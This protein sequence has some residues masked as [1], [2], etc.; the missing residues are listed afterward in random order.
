MS[1]LDKKTIYIID[2]SSLL[3]RS[4]YGLTSM[5]TSKGVP[6]QAIY[7]FCRAIKKIIDEMAPYLMVIAWDSAGQTTRKKVYDAYKAH[8]QATPNDLFEQKEAI[9]RWADEVG[10]FQLSVEGWEADDLIAQLVRE[11][12]DKNIL[13]IG[14]D[15]DLHQLVSESVEMYDPMKKQR[16]TKADIEK[17]YGFEVFKIPFFYALVGDSSDNIPGVKG[18]GE[19]GATALVQQFDSLDQMYEQIDQ[20]ASERTKKALLTHEKEARLS[21]QLFTLDAPEISVSLDQLHFDPAWWERGYQFFIEHEFKSLVPVGFKGVHEKKKESHVYETRE[22][23]VTLD[24][25]K[26]IVLQIRSIGACAVDTETMGESVFDQVMVG[27]S[28]AYNDYQ[29]FYI[30]LRHVGEEA[31]KKQIS[32][33]AALALIKPLFEDANIKKIFHHAKFDMHVFAREGINVQGLYFDSLIAASL[34]RTSDEKIGL[35]VLSERLLQEPMQTF[36]EVLQKHKNFSFVPL[37]QALN[38]AAYDAL[39]TYKLWQLFEKQFEQEVTLKKLFFE[40]EMPL[41]NVLFRMERAGILLDLDEM[42]Q[43]HVSVNVRI[44]EAKQKIIGFLEAQGIEAPAEINLN[45]PRQIEKLLFDDL[46][47]MPRGKSPKGARSTNQD[48]LIALSKEHPIPALIVQFR[49]LMKLK[50]TYI[51]P[52]PL[53]ISKQDQKIHTSYNQTAVATGRLS[54][55]DPNMQNIPVSFGQALNVRKAFIASP[56]K[57]LLSVDYS[58][59]ELRVLAHVTQDPH[60]M[61]AFLHDEDIHVK[62]ATQI[63]GIQKDQVTDE[64]RQVGKRINFSI[65]YGMTPFGLSK[66]LD[67]S[68][69][70]AKMYIDAYFDRYQGVKTWMDAV[71]EQAKKD[72]YVSTLW[73]RR[74]YIPELQEKNKMLFEAGR[75]AAVNTPIQGTTSELIKWAM[76]AIDHYCFEHAQEGS[77]LLQI[78]D[79]VVLEVVDQKVDAF[80]ERVKQIMEQVVLWSV[81][82]K[83]SVRMGKNWA[84]ITK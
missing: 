10:I 50:T 36:A 53:L 14:P 33:E 80:A 17:K 65:M 52:L 40:L 67:I 73:G 74:R 66:D 15:K 83:V 59:I 13:I 39:Q 26:E 46:G 23:V 56:G 22:L 84:S 72:G 57:T 21:Y 75:R 7:G 30:P 63:F 77:M 78:H 1:S 45:A 16:F 20:V 60:L 11:N 2:G 44:E 24:R 49:E 3:Y 41:C 71:V 29:A 32:I 42:K 68:L 58:Q 64:Q 51:E 70:D 37:E 38:Y 9:Q 79:E 18:I 81:P 69:K 4:Y 35:K 28:V 48:V 62:T 25:L 47:L 43:L 12:S 76:L 6:V 34:L 82:L 54:S 31:E 5:Q 61:D 19:K 55:N 27:F 8:R